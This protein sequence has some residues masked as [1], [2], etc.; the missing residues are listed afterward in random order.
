MLQI[1]PKSGKSNHMNLQTSVKTYFERYHVVTPSLSR[2]SST[3]SLTQGTAV[4]CFYSTALAAYHRPFQA[5][6][7]N[8]KF[9]LRCCTKHTF[10]PLMKKGIKDFEPNPSAEALSRS[11]KPF[12]LEL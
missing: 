2:S 11:R 9:P 10:T 7:S 6:D 12:A 3:H 1:H 5:G 8:T 4:P